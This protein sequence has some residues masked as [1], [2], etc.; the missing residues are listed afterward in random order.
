MLVQAQCLDKGYTVIFINGIFNTRAEADKSRL[1]LQSKIGFLING[2]SVIVKLGY[3]E[4]HVGGLG[5]L[6]QLFAQSYFSSVSDFDR[7]TILLQIYP[8]VTTQKMLLVGHSQ[9]SFY[10]NSIYNY[11]TNAGSKKKE[12]LAVYNVANLANY[13]AGGGRYLTSKGDGM[14]LTYNEMARQSGGLLALPANAQL[15]PAA[16]IGNGHSFTDAYMQYAGDRIVQEIG[17]SLL[18]LT[19]DSRGSEDCF[20]PPNPGLGYKT[21]QVFF[22][23]ADPAAEGVKVAGAK[24]YQGAVAVKDATVAAAGAAAGAAQ[25]FFARFAPE[26]RTENLPGSF[27]VVKS[28]YGSSVDE[29]DLEELLGTSQSGAVVLASAPPKNTKTAQDAPPPEPKKEGAVLGIQV[30]RPAQPAIPL[31]QLQSIESPGFG[32]GGGGGG[33]SVPVEAELEVPVE[34]PAKEPAETSEEET[35]ETPSTEEEPPPAEEPPPPEEQQNSEVV[36]ASQPDDSFLCALVL[37]PF[38]DGWRYCYTTNLSSQRDIDLGHLSGSLKSVT[39]ARE[40]NYGEIL[41]DYPWV[42]YI[43]CYTD[44]S[45]TQYCPDWINPALSRGQQMHMVGEF[46]TTT[47]DLKYWTAYFTDPARESNFD[48]SFPVVFRAEYYY[49][50]SINDNGVTIGAYGSP[51][52]PYYVILGFAP[53]IELVEEE[54]PPVQEQP[55]TPIVQEEHIDE[56]PVPPIVEEVPA[57]QSVEVPEEVVP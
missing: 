20:T 23:V 33:T 38:N 36:I 13:I 42:I 9:G 16:A 31:P 1:A 11:L 8:E 47:T 34:E 18:R 46:A 26:P 55:E 44:A 48:G 15:D 2:E 6:T 57:E 27:T 41:R 53:E 52:T 4:S 39:I 50:L 10:A 7:D 51:T 49:R 24:A 14:V 45:Y 22:A 37:E 30:E 35:P 5:D 21:Q 56:D 28:V 29:K 54:D 40:E 17:Q 25:S 19:P 3:N 32:G 12:S 43:Y